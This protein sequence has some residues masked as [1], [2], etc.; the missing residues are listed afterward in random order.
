MLSA[1]INVYKC[2]TGKN[3]GVKGWTVWIGLLARRQRVQ[4]RR[5]QTIVK[6]R[7]ALNVISQSHSAK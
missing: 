7:E 1:I 3:I 2:V 5:I 4:L 6:V